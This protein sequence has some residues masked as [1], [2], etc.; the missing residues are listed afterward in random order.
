MTNFRL[1]GDERNNCTCFKCGT[2]KS[3]KYLVEIGG[4]EKPVCNRCVLTVAQEEDV[5]RTLRTFSSEDLVKELLRRNKQKEEINISSDAG[6]FKID[7]N[8]MFHLS[9]E[10]SVGTLVADAEPSSKTGTSY[11]AVFIG[12]REKDSGNYVDLTSARVQ[13]EAPET[14]QLLNWADPFSEDYSDAYA[15]DVKDIR[16][17]FGE[18]EPEEPKKK[19]FTIC[20]AS[21]GGVTIEA[22]SEEEAMKKFESDAIQQDIGNILYQN[23][24]DITEVY[25]DPDAE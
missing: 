3:V 2:T 6:A 25:E 8:G 21:T 12:L 4:E 24:I 16:K 20:F 19:M 11:D 7:K 17:S 1:I 10:T 23:G 18:E 14:V 15:I 22:D 13:E 9:V 5:R